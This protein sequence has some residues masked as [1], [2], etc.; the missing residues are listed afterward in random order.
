[1]KSS[2]N[3]VG[4]KLP[5]LLS[6]WLL[7]AFACSQAFAANNS[8]FNFA[9]FATKTISMSGGYTDSYQGS[10]AS[11]VKGQYTNGDVGTNSD[12][13]CAI[14]L[15]GGATVYGKGLVGPAGTPA[16]DICLSGGSTVYQN[17]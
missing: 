5:A 14:Q 2:H 15:S 11:H 3:W 12:Q 10:P 1:M 6:F 16:T 7:I 8:T 17:S 9:V 13:S 4:R